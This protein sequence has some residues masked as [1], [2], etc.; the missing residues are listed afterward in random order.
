MPVASNNPKAPG[1]NAVRTPSFPK[2]DALQQE[3][4]LFLSPPNTTASIYHR[5]NHQNRFKFAEMEIP[6]RNFFLDKAVCLLQSFKT[7]PTGKTS[8]DVE[9]GLLQARGP[10][11]ANNS[12]DYCPGCR[13][14]LGDLGA[15]KIH[16]TISS[17]NGSIEQD[18]SRQPHSSIS[19][20]EEPIE[21][22]IKQQS[23][24]TEGSARFVTANDGSRDCIALLV[25]DTLIATIR[26]LYEDSHHLSGKQGPL[27]YIR[28]QARDLENSINQEEESTEGAESQEKITEL[29]DMV[30]KREAKML[31]VQQRRDEL[32][33]GANQ[34][35][36]NVTSSKAHIHWILENA[37]KKA[38]LFE[39]HRPLTPF[40]M[41][42][43]GSQS[44]TEEDETRQNTHDHISTGNGKQ[45]AGIKGTGSVDYPEQP[46]HHLVNIDDA[47]EDLQSLRQDAWESYNEALVTM[48]KVQNLFDKRQQSYETDLED[49]QQGFANGIYDISRSEFDRSKIWYE[50]KVTRALINAEEAFEA[51]KEQAQNVGAI[52]SDYDDTTDCYGC[53]EES[54]PESQLASYI[55]TKDWS[56]V[57]EWLARSEEPAEAQAELE[58]K[59][60]EVDVW[61]ADEVDPAD[62]ISQIDF[63]GYR[64]DIDRW[65]NIR[66]ERWEDMRTLVSGLEV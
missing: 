60:P 61:Y 5:T 56:H 66:F 19:P 35:E 2:E 59:R 14:S 17:S 13:R 31:K 25:T 27:E 3:K 15:H 49:Y 24:F 10:P 63:D 53:Y 64:K 29:R 18:I 46:S 43:D 20:S 4:V 50:Q 40:T 34:L 33:N 11:P 51:A 36:R 47:P 54:W 57:H 6:M 58:I 41:T 30:G 28:R 16:G 38:G 44:A 65:E 48:H 62:S 8:G 9:S 26:D 55:A 12:L 37:M 52:G 45:D 32:E 1:Q 42:E 21:Q 39:P 7:T 22:E 23:Q